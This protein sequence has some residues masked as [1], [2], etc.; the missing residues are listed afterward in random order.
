MADNT[1]IPVTQKTKWGDPKI[2]RSTIFNNVLALM[3]DKLITNNR[4]WASPLIARGDDQGTPAADLPGISN[5]KA[6]LWF[7]ELGPVF[8]IPVARALELN[9]IE[10]RFEDDSSG[11]LA[12]MVRKSDRFE[13]AGKLPVGRY[14]LI[15]V[16]SDSASNLDLGGF[17]VV[18]GT[19]PKPDGYPE[20][21]QFYGMTTALGLRAAWLADVDPSRSALMA[22]QLAQSAT[23]EGAD[24]AATQ[25]AVITLAGAQ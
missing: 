17:D 12:T 9:Q 6:V 23:L 16:S 25:R 1:V 13:W 11:R 5:R 10:I 24:S 4:L 8:Q 20:L 19:A 18:A 14:S 22:Y 7:D 3:N 2:Q 15:G 21:V